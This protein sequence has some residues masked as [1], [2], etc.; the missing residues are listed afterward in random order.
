MN[1]TTSPITL[2]DMLKKLRGQL[3][4]AGIENPALDA[5]LLVRQGGQFSDAE[6]ISGGSVPLSAEAIENIEEFALRRTA[7]EPISRIF[8]GREFYGR[9]FTVTP[10]TLDPRPDTETLIEAALKRAREMG[11]DRPLKILDLGTGTGCI[12]ITLLAEL[13]TATGVAVDISPAAL[14][15]ARQ[16]AAAHGV[17]SRADFRQGSWFEPLREGE[18]FDLILS[19]PPY[20][21]E[22]DIESLAKEVRNHDPFMALSGGK[23]GLAAYKFILKD[24]KKYLG[25]GG[26]ALFEIGAGQEKDLVRLMEDSMMTRE[27]SYPDMSGILRVVEM[28]CG[29][30]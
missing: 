1:Q 26:Y 3:A 30:K 15:V 5:R 7:G 21:P 20:I 24:L 16:N 18:I 25:C 2:D 9:F 29:E 4:A 6:M 17:E 11:A 22:S 10:D 28:S 8:G 14:D 23:D 27:E 12:L 13:P 19:N